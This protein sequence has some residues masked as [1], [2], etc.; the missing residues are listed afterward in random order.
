MPMFTLG[1]AL[2]VFALLVLIGALLV[3]RK[4]QKIL[5]APVKKTARRLACRARRA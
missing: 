3:R 1:I 4:G 5:S 2:V